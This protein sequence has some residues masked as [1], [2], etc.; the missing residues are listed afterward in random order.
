M[1]PSARCSAAAVSPAASPVDLD[2]AETLE[3]E[4]A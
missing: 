3:I 2:R 4:A 1:T